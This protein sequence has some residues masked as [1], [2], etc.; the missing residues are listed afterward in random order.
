MSD[1]ETPADEAV[2]QNSKERVSAP[3]SEPDK[4]AF[5]E[6]KG[7]YLDR[8][9]WTAF[10]FATLATFICY[11][12][13]MAPTVTLEDSG[14]LAVAAD[15]FGVPHPPGYPIWTLI[16]WIFTKIFASPRPHSH[17]QSP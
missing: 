11:F 4:K 13:T 9:D 6:W 10:W 3:V 2:D 7:R 14:E 8:S 12:W 5:P 16:C 15:Y 17:R 1:Q